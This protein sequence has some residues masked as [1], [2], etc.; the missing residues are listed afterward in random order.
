M[1]ADKALTFLF[2]HGFSGSAARWT[3][4]TEIFRS[5]GRVL[6]VNLPGHGG[7]PWNRETLGQMA[8][9]VAEGL[10]HQGVSRNVVVVASSFGGLVTLDLWKKNPGLFRQI[11]FVG[12]VPCFTCKDDFPAGLSTAKIEGLR[13]QISR[14][15]NVAMDAFFRS[16]FT[17]RERAG[18]QYAVIKKQRK[19]AALPSAE[20]LNA[21]LDILGAQDSRDG[22]T[23]VTVPVNFIFGDA[24]PIC[25][26]AVV[27][28][29]RLICPRAKIAVMPGCGHLPFLSEPDAFNAL[30]KECVS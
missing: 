7:A 15:V 6:A 17:A 20:V 29:L 18:A 21:Y 8:D 5:L 30:L 19:G 22:L 13:D 27:E 2:I 12:S 9:G 23:T 3:F 28:P 1:P 14:N 11:I 24:D 25:P 10:V 26:L 16:L 4:Q